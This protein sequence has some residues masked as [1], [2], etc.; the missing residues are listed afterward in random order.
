MNTRWSPAIT[1]ALLLF[2]LSPLAGQA[3]QGTA[4]PAPQTEGRGGRGGGDPFRGQPRINALIV[5]GGCCH[6]YAGE[7]KVMMDAIG[8]ALPVDWTV[9][10]QGGRGTRGSMPVYA[11]PD[12]AKRFD[13]VIHNECLADVDDPAYI[14]QITAAHRNGPPALVI[15]CAMHSYRAATIDDWREFLGVT[16]RQHTRPFNI[17]VKIAAKDHSAM[18]GFKEDWVTPI[19]E[20][21]VIEKIGPHTTALATA[22]SPEDKMEYPLVWASEYGGTTRVFG[23]TLGHGADTWADPVYQDLL[24]RGFKWALRR[25]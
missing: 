25:E 14:R 2:A 22:V 8:K 19:D 16:S 4:A 9:V 5:S 23:T 13:I 15:H 21:Y 6:D 7:A 18:K 11:S 10:V 3:P 12:W 17:P 1:T 20:L 24:I